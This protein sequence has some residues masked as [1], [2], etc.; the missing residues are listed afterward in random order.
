MVTGAVQTSVRH[1]SRLSVTDDA[2]NHVQRRFQHLVEPHLGPLLRFARRRTATLSD[3][4]DSVQEACLRAWMAFSELREETKVRAWL[5][6]ILR[7]VLSDDLMRDTRRL[8]LAGTTPLDDVPEAELAGDGDAV[9]SEVMARISSEA[10]HEAL[11]AI[12]P[13][14]AAPV[15]M[16]DIDGMKYR[17][18][19]EALEIPIGTV[20]SRISRGRVLLARAVASRRTLRLMSQPVVAPTQVSMEHG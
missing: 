16:H 2:Q 7:T 18:I 9:F 14:F 8:R 13:D 20:M 11:A 1:G 5:Y 10:V 6:R 15:E 4:E 3:A 19:S 12:H 17:E